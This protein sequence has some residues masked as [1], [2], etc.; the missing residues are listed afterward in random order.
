MRITASTLYNYIQCPH[1]VW[2]DAHG[3]KNEKNPEPNPFVK[4]LWEK[5]VAHERRIVQKLGE[6]TDLSQGTLEDRFELSLTAMRDGK[7]LIYQAVLMNDF[8]LGIPDLLRK[9]SD[10]TYVPIDIKSGMGYAGVDDDEND[11]GK[12]KKHYA[13]QLSLYVE[14]LMG[15]G[16]AQEKQ[17]I[18]IDIH[19]SEKVY[20]LATSQGP[21]T[22]QTYWELYQE[23]K[24]I[25]KH[26]QD[27]QIENKPALGSVCQLCHWQM[28]CKNWCEREDDMTRLFYLGRSNRDTMERDLGIT[29]VEDIITLNPKAL[30]SEKK[31][32]KPEPFLH[33][34]AETSLNKYIRRAELMKNNSKPVIYEAYQFPEVPY[35]L[36]FDIE[37]DPTNEFVYMHGIYERSP[38]GERYLDFT[39][40]E[41][42][43]NAEKSAWTQFWD[44][45]RSFSEDQYAVYYYAPH[46]KTVYRKLQQQYPDVISVEGLEDFFG[47]PKVIDLYN[48]VI[49]KL[50]D[51]PLG[52]YSLK[53]I[54]TYL[55]FKW[56]DETP[57]G[58]LSIQWFNEY[59]KTKNPKHLQRL[60]EYN[61]DD[62][63]ATMRVKDG[64]MGMMI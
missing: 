37:D 6:L 49:Q 31:R 41:L 28:S 57:S 10:G 3:P 42:S 7:A 54:A 14:L 17:G 35:E 55:G 9:N 43:D 11:D 56:R 38:D 44:F 27:N 51:W 50:T 47:N 36:F 58:A 52:S 39:A 19:G 63:K 34:I 48:Q 1:R 29:T 16:F 5:G 22:P 45:I 30:M 18:I 61:E 4:L 23:V 21:R 20:D 8:L 60:R 32:R 53:A 25:T 59:L 40:T 15:L 12:L 64:I 62:C 46:E 26:L 13:V 33:R 24:A 2:R